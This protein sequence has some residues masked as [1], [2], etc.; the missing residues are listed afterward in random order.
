MNIEIILINKPFKICYNL[1]SCL[2]IKESMLIEI[3]HYNFFI[4]T[5]IK[6]FT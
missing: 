2:S 4:L 6:G 1:N 5:F 3:K